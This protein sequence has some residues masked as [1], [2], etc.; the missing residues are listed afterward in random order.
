MHLDE[1]HFQMTNLLSTSIDLYINK[2]GYDHF[3]IYI[4]IS[5][6]TK[7]SGLPRKIIFEVT[8][9]SINEL[10]NGPSSYRQKGIYF[11]W[12]FMKW[13][14]WSIRTWTSVIWS[15]IGWWFGPSSFGQFSEWKMKEWICLNE[16]GPN[17]Q[18]ISDQITEVQVLIAQNYNFMKTH[19]K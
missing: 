3:K 11:E 5:H 18:P 9:H 7:Y 4:V 1:R 19:L 12:V 15:L 14:F 6:H 10:E 17:H 16:L 2:L 13:Q 8:G